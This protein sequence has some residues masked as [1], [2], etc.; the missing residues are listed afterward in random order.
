MIFSNF[1]I[2]NRLHKLETLTDKIKAVNS[3]KYNSD[4]NYKNQIDNELKNKKSDALKEIYDIKLSL[5]ETM[6]ILLN[7]SCYINKSLLKHCKNLIKNISKIDN[8]EEL[9]NELL[10]LISDFKEDFEFDDTSCKFGLNSDFKDPP[11]LSKASMQPI[12]DIVSKSQKKEI[13]IFEA[14]CRD[15]NSLRRFKECNSNC[16]TYGIE[17]HQ[18]LV[19]E[20]K[21]YNTVIKKGVLLGSRISNH[22]FDIVLAK[23]PISLN[24]NDNLTMGGFVS[25][26]ERN[27]LDTFRYAQKDN[28][29]ILL[30]IPYF[31]LN[32][33]MCLAIAKQ[34]KNI[35]I[36][37]APSPFFEEN[38]L[39][40]IYGQKCSGVSF[41]L[42][43]YNTLRAVVDIDSIVDV[44]ID[45]I[46]LDFTLPYPIGKIELF[47]GSEIDLDELY[48]IV[49]K[50][51]L[52]NEMLKSQE[53]KKIGQ[54]TVRPLLPFNIGQVGLVLTSGC[55]DGVI[56][57][58]DGVHLV[59]GQVVKD[60]TIVSEREG[61]IV[62]SSET[63]GNKVELT[64]LLPDGTIKKL[65]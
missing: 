18:H 45:E 44:D 39:V 29:I 28:S 51:P 11:P 12:L 49:D 6:F 1:T 38:K 4:E 48:E 61:N 65:T 63:I 62:T 37:K 23:A 46:K 55:L 60:S 52:F 9:K 57:E 21:K 41:E 20:A 22:V 15:G 42:D 10:D 64:V 56:E 30:S 33:E 34:L 13:N 31:R 53:V 27:Y 47:K 26:T 16:L 2:K 5:E 50:S 17:Q 3:E 54:D 24:L 35:K 59:K 40:Y 43:D 7:G 32:Q 58:E 8:L 19:S 25:R 36:F 14:N